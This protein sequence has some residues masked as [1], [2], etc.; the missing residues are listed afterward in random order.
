MGKKS[1]KVVLEEK[2]EKEKKY[3]IFQRLYVYQ[4]ERFPIVTFA[5]Y[6]LCIVIGVFFITDAY[7]AKESGRFLKNSVETIFYNRDYFKMI[8]MFIVGFL[9]FFMVRVID[10]HKDFEE[11]SKFRNYRP[12]P[13]GLIS[14]R[15]LKVLFVISFIA[16]F[17]ITTL[18]GGSLLLLVILWCAVLLLANDFFIKDFID[19]HVLVGVILDEAI[20]PVLA[21]LMASFCVEEHLL[22]YLLGNTGFIYLVYL[23]YVISWIVELARKIRCKKDEEKGVKTYTQVFG[24][25]KAVLLLGLFEMFAYMLQTTLLNR[26]Y[27]TDCLFI[28]LTVMVIN[29]LFVLTENRF[30]SKLVELAANVYII[31]VYLSFIVLAFPI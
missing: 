21:L 16:Q 17:L 7:A 24:I 30:F 8:P 9:Q 10:E 5:L 13:R 25:P 23:T 2:I 14:L 22:F 28:F 11:D 20:M 29:V 4:K 18:C 31:V 27:D 26:N 3:N 15:V 19:R 1:K 6:I 12:V